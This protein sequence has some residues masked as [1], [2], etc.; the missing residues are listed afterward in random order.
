[1]MVRPTVTR[2]L[3]SLFELDDVHSLSGPLNKY[4][5]NDIIC[6]VHIFSEMSIPI[7]LQK[8]CPGKETKIY[9]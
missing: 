8:M 4:G 3:P 6:N 1:M 2:H 7:S 9:L 5:Y